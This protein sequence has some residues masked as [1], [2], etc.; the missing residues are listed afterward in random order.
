MQLGVAYYRHFYPVIRRAQEIIQSGEIGTPV[1]AQMNA[2]EW[3][4]PEPSYPRAW[5]LKREL[6]GG[7][8]MFDFGCHRLEVLLDLFGSFRHVKAT[9]ASS[10]FKREVEDVAVVTLRFENGTCATVTVAHSANEPQDTFDIF[11]SRGSIHIPILNGGRLRVGTAS[12]EREELHPAAANIH[13][14]LID[15]FALSVIENRIPVV[16]GYIG[17]T[18][19]E[20]EDEI[21]RQSE[22]A[23]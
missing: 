17:R 15:D 2:F 16:D 8:P 11:G 19:A 20:I 13:Q 6:S 14:P 7:G 12:G 10:Y 1:V 4:A 22:Q 9:T 21:T 23:L 18:V 3:F 5:L